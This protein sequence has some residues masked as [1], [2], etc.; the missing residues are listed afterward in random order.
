MPGQD[1]TIHVICYTQ[2][3]VCFSVAIFNDYFEETA[4]L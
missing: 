3:V 1:Y 2:F 4:H